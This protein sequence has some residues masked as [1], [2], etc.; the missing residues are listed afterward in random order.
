MVAEPPWV[1]LMEPPR[2]RRGRLLCRLAFVLPT[3]LHTAEELTRVPLMDGAALH[4]LRTRPVTGQT[5]ELY[6]LFL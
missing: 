2:A 1:L 5:A 4:P 3:K 6:K